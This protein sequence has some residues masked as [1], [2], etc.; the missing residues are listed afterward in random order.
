[1]Y[2]VVVRV[3]PAAADVAADRLWS[4]GVLAVEER[5]PGDGSLELWTSLGDP[6]DPEA[7]GMLDDPDHRWT[8]RLVD[9]DEGVADSWR[10]HAH[11]VIVDERLIVHP[12]WVAPPATVPEALV[13]AIEPGSTFGL[14]D[15]PTTRLSLLAVRHAL[16]RFAAAEQGAEPVDGRP[17][18]LDVGCG[19]GVLAIAAARWGAGRCVGLDIATACVPITLD[20]ARRNGVAGRVQVSTDTVADAVAASGPFDVV[21]ANILAN[22]LILLAPALAARVRPAGRIA[23]SGIL[24][25]QAPD[26][27][28]AYARW[29]T[30]RAWGDGEGWV[31][32]E[33]ERAR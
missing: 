31:L 28:A 2:A 3:E 21:V 19:S 20:N 33:G 22:P 8:W 27:I 12:A 30:L 5:D 32:L 29:F 15:H 9:V 6:P 24:E 7:L 26:V 23:L 16:E 25:A 1:M 14:G 18:V 17:A 10:D 11:P 13:L 4:L